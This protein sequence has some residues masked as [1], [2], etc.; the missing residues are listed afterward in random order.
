MLLEC[1]RWINNPQYQ[2]VIFRRTSTQVRNPGGLWDTS[3]TIYPLAGGYPR[4]SA[5]EWVFPSGAK[6]RF[7]HMEHDKNRFDWQGSQIPLIGFDEVSHFSWEQFVYMYSR[8]R[9]TSGVPGY[10]RCTTN[11]DPDSWVRRMI[12][13]WIGEDGYPIQERSGVIRWFVIINDKT[14]WGDTK[15]ELQSRF[16]GSLP[17]KLFFCGFNRFR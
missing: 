8:N 14:E 7:A 12:D 15:N 3:V 2:A 9:S 10:I 13:W 5:L 4:E 1:L 11:P 6:I 17:K 16:P